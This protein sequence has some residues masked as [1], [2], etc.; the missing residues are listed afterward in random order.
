MTEKQPTTIK[1]LTKFL[2]E[3]STKL[4]VINTNVNKGPSGMSQPTTFMNKGFNKFKATM[5]SATK[6]IKQLK[7]EL[8]QLKKENQDLAKELE[9]TKRNLVKMK[10]YCHGNLKTKGT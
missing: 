7:A 1:E 2:S 3:L 8:Q 9:D 5:D 4:D 6:E 10:Q